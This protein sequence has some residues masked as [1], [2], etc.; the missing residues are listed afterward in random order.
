[1]GS[2]WICEF[3]WS[4]FGLLFGVAL[5]GLLRCELIEAD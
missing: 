1:M 4:G 2:K 5:V 3:S